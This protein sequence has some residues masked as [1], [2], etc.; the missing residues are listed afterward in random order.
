MSGRGIQFGLAAAAR[1][2]VLGLSLGVT[3]ALRWARF[4]PNNDPILAVMMPCAKRGRVAAAAFPIAAM[5]LFDVL[6]QRVGVWTA[7]TAGTY[8]I[9]GLAFAHVYRVLANRGR[10]VGMGTFL[11]SGIAGVLV[12]D[13]VTGPVMSSLLFRMSFAEAF[14]GQIPF[15]LKHLASVSTYAVV[16][17]P[18]LDR[19]FHEIERGRE[20]IVHR[21]AAARAAS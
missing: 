13:F 10:N 4:F 15:T 8:G 5:A 1:C 7:V 12:F 14:I 18:A 9:L 6:S 19:A 3:T 20:W 16:V 2:A 17:S 21:L 11:I